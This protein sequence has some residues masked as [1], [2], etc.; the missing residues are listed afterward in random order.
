[1]RRHN[2]LRQLRGY[3]DY[4]GRVFRVQREHGGVV[5]G[6]RVRDTKDPAGRGLVF[7]VSAGCSSC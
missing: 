7:M 3:A 5:A 1:M 2:A 4:E 6:E